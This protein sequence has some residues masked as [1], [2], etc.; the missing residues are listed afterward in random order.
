MRTIVNSHSDANPVVKWQNAEIR[1]FHNHLYAMSPLLPHNNKIILSFYLKRALNL[2]GDLGILRAKVSKKFEISAKNKIFT[3]RF[4][5]GG[6]E[7]RLPKR[8]GTHQ[9]KKLMQ[10]WKIQPWLRDRIPLVYCSEKIIAVVGYYSVSGVR[11]QISP[12]F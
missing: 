8:K 5:Q 9:L 12:L 6:E 2:P 10:E 11:F 4:R 3:V 1:R 7:L